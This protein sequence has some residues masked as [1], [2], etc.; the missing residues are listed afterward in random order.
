MT[1]IVFVFFLAL[2]APCVMAAKEFAHLSINNNNII[3][4]KNENHTGKIFS[5]VTFL[6][7]NKNVDLVF[8]TDNRKWTDLRLKF[9]DTSF[10]KDMTFMPTDF[11]IGNDQDR[12]QFIMKDEYSKDMAKLVDVVNSGL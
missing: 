2:V 5:F 7:T 9:D 3:A 8:E 12:S 11:I 1:R 4:H 10:S 6:L